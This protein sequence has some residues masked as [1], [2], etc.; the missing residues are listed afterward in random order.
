MPRRPRLVVPGLA[1]HVVQRGVDRQACF[2]ADADRAF[3][4]E[5]L[6]HLAELHGCAIHAYVLMTNHVHLLLTP[7]TADG[8]GRLLQALGRRHVRRFNDCHGR[9]GTLWEGR[10]KSCLVGED[11]YLLAC[12]R[13]IE[14]NPVRA[15]MVPHPARFTWSSHRA[16]AG[17]DAQGTRFLRLHETILALGADANARIA[18]YR[19]MFETAAPPPEIDAI[20]RMTAGNLALGST[21]FAARIAALLGRRTTPARRGRPPLKNPDENRY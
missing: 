16:N 2:L 6:G 12:H 5:A 20:R 13:Y 15:G 1:L 18:A 7:S 21:G 14:L 3:Y 8:P 10:F 4:L 11:A 19:A 9:T 17:Y